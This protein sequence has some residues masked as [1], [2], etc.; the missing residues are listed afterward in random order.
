MGNGDTVI[1]MIRSGGEVYLSAA[2]VAMWL[3]AQGK[4][5]DRLFNE[6]KFPQWSAAE[7]KFAQQI[8]STT[9]K[10]LQDGVF[11]IRSRNL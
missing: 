10:V 4:E 6:R 5:T 11:D 9:I 2:D 3:S 7:R 8:C 1:R